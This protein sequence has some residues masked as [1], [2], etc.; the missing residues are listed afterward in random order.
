MGA[1]VITNDGKVVQATEAARATYNQLFAD[2]LGMDDAGRNFQNWYNTLDENLSDATKDYLVQN[3]FNEAAENR[4]W[5]RQMDASNTQYQRAV[6]D[7][8][9]AGLNPF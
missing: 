4:A 3:Y 2:G 6:A 7:L 1:D 5:A 9:K 8:K